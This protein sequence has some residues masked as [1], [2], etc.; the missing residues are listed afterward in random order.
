[1]SH[2]N[3][4]HICLIMAMMAEAE[5]VIKILNLSPMSHQ[6]F[7]RSPVKLYRGF[8]NK[9]K[10]T[11]C[12]SG[13]D[14]RHNA[15]LIGPVPATLNASL[16]CQ[17]LCPDIVMSCGTAGGFNAKDCQIGT[18]ILSKEKCI[19]HDRRVPLSGYQ[20]SGVGSFPVLDVERMAQALNLKTGVISSGSSLLKSPDDISVLMEHDAIAKEM[21]AAAVAWVCYEYN[22]KFI[23]LK[24]ITNILDKPEASEVQFV[25]NLEYA[26]QALAKQLANIVE[27]LGCHAP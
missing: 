21:E 15:D 10:I 8:H 7:E 24:S 2:V 25:E 20:E 23:G 13:V 22:V 27:Y 9:V 3:A 26:S 5:S 19:F 12:L 4:P 1:M 16:V 18:V 11:L 6:G 17:H 14:T